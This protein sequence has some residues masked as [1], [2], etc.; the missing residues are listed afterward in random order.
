MD[1]RSGFKFWEV[2]LLVIAGLLL[3][4]SATVYFTGFPIGSYFFGSDDTPGGEAIGQVG[5]RDGSLK[6]EKS[7]ASEF[8]AVNQ[9][10]PLYTK[11]VLVTA[12][13]AR[14]TV[15]LDDGSVIEMA[16]D[17]MIRLE[18]EKRKDVSGVFRV[19]HV[20]VIS[21]EVKGVTAPKNKSSKLLIRNEER[22]IEVDEKQPA[23][24]VQ[25]KPKAAAPRPSASA[26]PGAAIAPSRS[27]PSPSGAPSSAP[28]PS[29]DRALLKP[30][31]AFMILSPTEDAA[32]SV[33]NDLVQSQTGQAP[34]LPVTIEIGL[35]KYG[36]FLLS[37]AG[38]GEA[39]G[40]SAMVRVYLLQADGPPLLVAQ[41]AAP[42]RSDTPV[43]MIFPAHQPGHY[44]IEVKRNDLKQNSAENLSTSSSFRVAPEFEGIVLHKPTFKSEKTS[45][46]EPRRS[47]AFL[48]WDPYPGVTNYRLQI[49]DAKNTRQDL[50]VPT[51]N[52]IAVRESIS[53]TTR[54]YVVSSNLANGWIVRSPEEQFVFDFTPPSPVTPENKAVLNQN[55][56]IWNG[57]GIL[58]TWQKTGVSE[59]YV[60]EISADPTFAKLIVNRRQTDNFLVFKP[61][62]RDMTYYWRIRAMAQGNVSQPSETF[63]FSVEHAKPKSPQ[64]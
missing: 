4:G 1:K 59:G 46:D 54:K 42:F 38:G 34:T 7:G 23:P 43:A 62:R 47:Q 50:Q 40:T 51:N 37:S 44:R 41:Q 26:N 56:N 20:Q 21:G 14:A 22:E 8:I 9:G 17:T 27:N 52:F 58:L 53:D 33:A 63:E 2:S 29:L 31:P 36:R 25:A 10:T 49:T 12:S 35:S 32:L 28:S 16:P 24:V 57:K 45:E 30:R 3:V 11:D 60:L 55:S 6:R 64:S 48:S 39:K 5:K 15:Q 13:D 61:S 18:L 19:N